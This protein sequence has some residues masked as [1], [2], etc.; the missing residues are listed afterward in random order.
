MVIPLLFTPQILTNNTTALVN[1]GTWKCGMMLPG[2]LDLSKSRTCAQLR[3]ALVQMARLEKERGEGPGCS[4]E[5]LD[6]EEDEERL[7][8]EMMKGRWMRI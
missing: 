5:E 4:P 3:A 8:W 2:H 6:E 7:L 1:A